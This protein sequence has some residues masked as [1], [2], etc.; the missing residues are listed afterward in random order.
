MTAVSVASVD[1]EIEEEA[2]ARALPSVADIARAAALAALPAGPDSNLVILLA[3]DAEVSA[4]NDQF[5]G[6]PTPTNVLS[7]PAAANP[8]GHLGDL[9]LAFGVCDGEA[10][11]QGKPLAD[12]LRHLVVHGVLHLLG[13]DH[14]EQAE[15]DAMEALERD[16]LAGLGVPDPYAEP[17]KDSSTHGA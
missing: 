1:V 4:L 7:F 10:R 12:H 14:Q 3:G 11:A 2:W 9:A 8:E 5:R 15:G 16:I 6:K 17:M 13:Y